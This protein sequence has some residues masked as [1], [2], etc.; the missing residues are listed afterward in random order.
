[1]D[2]SKTGVPFATAILIGIGSGFLPAPTA[3][4]GQS[5]DVPWTTPATHATPAQ[6]HSPRIT[7]ARIN[8]TVLTAKPTANRRPD[9]HPVSGLD[10]VPDPMHLVEIT[11]LLTT[12]AGQPADGHDIMLRSRE[13]NTRYTTT[14]LPGGTFLLSQVMPGEDYRLDVTP[15]AMLQRYFRKP[16]RIAAD[17]ESLHITLET[18]EVATLIGAIVNRDGTA[19]PDFP[20]TLKSKTRAR[21]QQGVTTDSTGQ[22]K[23]VGVPVGEIVISSL[24]NRVMLADGYQVTVGSVQPLKLVVDAGNQEVGGLVFDQYNEPIAGAT[25]MLDWEAV[26]GG[27]RSTGY[28][29]TSSDPDGRFSL[30]NIGPGEHQLIVAS[31]SGAASRQ[32]VDIRD[33]YT[34]LTIV[35]E[36]VWLDN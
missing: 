6:Q 16:L 31:S 7:S 25:I 32:T 19:V 36:Q 24:R 3:P 14:S 29:R 22:F 12:A 2:S 34:D 18:L 30:K 8:G 4:P 20:I 28:H 17:T 15:A 33:G 35:L 26:T 11:G 10:S 21:W 1:M 13:R 27:A 9:P 5:T 23:V